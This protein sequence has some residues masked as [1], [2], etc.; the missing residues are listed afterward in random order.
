MARLAILWV[1]FCL[2]GDSLSSHSAEKEKEGLLPVRGLNILSAECEMV[3][4]AAEKSNF[5]LQGYGS[6]LGLS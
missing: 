1:S 3:Y 4:I 6:A 2:Y 5:F